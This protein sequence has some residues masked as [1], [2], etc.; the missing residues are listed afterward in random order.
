MLVLHGKLV[1]PA[2]VLCCQDFILE[3]QACLLLHFL[4]LTSC[5]PSRETFW[6]IVG[7]ELAKAIVTLPGWVILIMLFLYKTVSRK[8]HILV[9]LLESIGMVSGNWAGPARPINFLAFSF[10]TTI[11]AL[12]NSFRN[13]TSSGVRIHWLMTLQVQLLVSALLRLAWTTEGT[14]SSCYRRASRDQRPISILTECFIYLSQIIPRVHLRELHL[15][16][17]ASLLSSSCTLWYHCLCLKVF[18]VQVV[19]KRTS[20]YLVK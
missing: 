18:L 19:H 14:L 11:A 6:C 17:F 3:L 8:C 9:F 2:R 7:G 1:T 10:F 15:Y 20:T 16:N 13:F 12:S 5:K 4:T